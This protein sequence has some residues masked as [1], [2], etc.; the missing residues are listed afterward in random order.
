MSDLL[1]NVAS[2]S[3]Q[4]TA[5]IIPAAIGASWAGARCAR[6]QLHLWQTLFVI[7]VTLPAAGWLAGPPP[8]R[9]AAFSRLE[10]VFVQDV[11]AV[12]DVRWSVAVLILLGSGAALRLAALVAGGLA[13]RRVVARASAAAHVSPDALP[14][15]LDAAV[16]RVSPDVQTPATVGARRPVILVPPA[17]MDHPLPIQR[18]VLWHEWRHIVRRDWIRRV[19]EEV[20]CA[21]LWFHPAARLAVRRLDLAREMVVD[22]DTLVATGDRRAYAE[23]LLAFAGPAPAVPE[24]LLSFIHPRDLSPRIARIVQEG[25]MSTRAHV[26]AI[27]FIGAMATTT[28]LAAAAR[29]PMSWRPADVRLGSLEQDIARVGEEGVVAP[30]IVHE[31]KPQ[32]TAAALQAR[33]QGS[34]EMA[35]VIDT[36]GSVG[37]VEVT[38]SLDDEHGLDRAA[39]EAARQWRFT[40]GQKAGKPIR[41]EVALE[42]TFTLK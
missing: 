18:A 6:A 19:V 31:V 20:W 15:G 5:L 24:P 39:V 8:E 4:L 23:A 40:P 41:V 2:Y 30:T 13:I 12:S 27:A 25:P 34:V 22:E 7:A 16:V 28:A 26:M 9:A 21:L 36:D 17:F 33:I 37:R 3:L 35:V 38:K 42:M 10:Q 14:P 11:V 32:Y 29:Y 1:A